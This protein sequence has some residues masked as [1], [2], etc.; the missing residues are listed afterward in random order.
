MRTAGADVYRPVRTVSHVH[1]HTPIATTKVAIRKVP[2]RMKRYHLVLA[3]VAFTAISTTVS[4]STEEDRQQTV[5]NY[6]ENVRIWQ[7]DAERGVTP[8]QRGGHPNYKHFSCT[9]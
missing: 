7:L 9:E 2:I 4:W 3:A 8:Y 6:C 1:T 5:S